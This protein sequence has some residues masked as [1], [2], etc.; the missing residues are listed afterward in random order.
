MSTQ[1]MGVCRLIVS[2]AAQ[3]SRRGLLAFASLPSR[4]CKC[5]RCPARPARSCARRRDA[6]R[7]LR[8]PVRRASCCRSHAR[9]AS[10]PNATPSESSS[11]SCERDYVSSA[12]FRRIR[13]YGVPLALIAKFLLA[14]FATA[15][16]PTAAAL[17]A[18]AVAAGA[19]S[20]CACHRCAY[21][22]EHFAGFRY[23]VV[24]YI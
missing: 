14:A 5:A 3:V 1:H 2:L 11:D 12:R 19:P 16:Q 23:G 24:F 9:R 18:L 7:G 22:V 10:S 21:E 13:V 6:Y 15:H 20:L 17:A 4:S 8:V